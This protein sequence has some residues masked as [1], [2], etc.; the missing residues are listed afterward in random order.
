[1]KEIEEL[2]DS[3]FYNILKTKNFATFA[4]TTTTATTTATTITT[5]TT[6][7][8]DG[9]NLLGSLLSG[10]LDKIDWFGSL[11][12]INHLPTKEEGSAVAQI[13]EGGIFGPAS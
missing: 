6:T 11:F 12:G 4:T 1:A 9:S 2:I 10:R 8:D 3:N 5:T 7:I 13:F